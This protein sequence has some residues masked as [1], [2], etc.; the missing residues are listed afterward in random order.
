MPP[1][2]EPD[3]TPDTTFSLGVDA[4]MLGD[5]GH[6][7]LLAASLRYVCRL[8]KALGDVLDLGDLSHVETTG[9][10]IVIAEIGWDLAGDC[11]LRGQVLRSTAP[12]STAT[13]AAAP[14]EVDEVVDS[15]LQ[16]LESADSVRW[17]AVV[18]RDLPLLHTDAAPAAA[19]LGQVGLRA[20]G[21]L[22]GIGADLRETCVWLGFARGTLILSPLGAHCLVLSVDTQ[23]LD[24][25]AL[26]SDVVG[27]QAALAPHDL[28]RATTLAERAAALA[29]AEARAA[30]EDEEFALPPINDLPL[31]GARFAGAPGAKARENS[32]ARRFRR[33]LVPIP[34]RR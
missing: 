22:G 27:T 14:G 5:D 6:G 3:S 1:T 4:A 18:R 26:V 12:S 20:L 31:T 29:E 13:E 19:A 21:I 11:R 15:C 33:P 24:A 23:R 25:T 17:A 9:S 10:T 7:G 30:Y 16:T 2:T 34:V 28:A 32:G 8:A